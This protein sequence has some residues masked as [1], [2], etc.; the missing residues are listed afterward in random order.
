[1][2]AKYFSTHQVAEMAGIHRDTLL[3]WLREKR[4]A[5]PTRD[6]RGWRTF[7]LE[8]VQLVIHY[9]KALP[10]E[11]DFPKNKLND[12]YLPFGESIRRLVSLD[13]DFIGAKTGFLTHSI[14]PYPAKY[15]PQIPNALIQEL[16]SVGETILDPFCGSG[17]SLVEA[18]R[19][20]RN[21]IGVDANPLA[22]LISSVKTM[23]I[24]DTDAAFLKALAQR[25]TDEGE[26]LSNNTL[27]LFTD[28]PAFA[29]LKFTP[30][31]GVDEWFDA[32]V[33]RELSYIKSICLELE[34]PQIRKLALV[35]MSSIIITVSRQDSD[36]RY[37]RRKKNIGKGDTLILFGRALSNIA[38]RVLE[39]NAE[40]QPYHS[41]DIL[42]A[43][44][45][46]CPDVGNVDLVVCSPPYPNAYSYHLYH[47]T[48]MLWLDI[49]QP[50]FKRQEI[51]SHRKY[52][53]KSANA[54]TMETFR[55]EL[56]TILRWVS[57]HLRLNR[58]ACFV[59][60]DST[61][62]G[63]RIKNDELLIQMGEKVG[64]KLE[65]NIPRTLQS[66]KKSFNPTI[67]KIK[68]EH[69][70]ILRNIGT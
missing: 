50:E 3:R 26:A 64:F 30:F 63:E 27:M 44:I 23:S 62:K 24:T 22:C 48:R 52:S 25:F 18:L 46:D 32:H 41:V 13:W 42:D 21:A 16:S 66:S 2:Y 55:D 49:D 61:I 17:T 35:A 47:R 39:F 10:I 15:I 5:E 20:D 40:L 57:K 19:L 65:A 67:G 59:I 54:A 12:P 6:R 36:T 29:K 69:I 68:Q 60:G 28:A 38:Q 1:M 56:E 31:K 4:V 45:L 7:T 8:E 34:T 51:G 11:K 58:H 43:D 70:V 14:H 37:V 9:A 33:I 53:S